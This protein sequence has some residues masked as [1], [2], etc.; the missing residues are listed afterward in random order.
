MMSNSGQVAGGISEAAVQ[1]AD[2]A[3]RQ[4]YYGYWRDTAGGCE[5]VAGEIS[6]RAA[7]VAALPH[8]ASPAGDV[9]G[10]PVNVESLA[11]FLHDTRNYGYCWPGANY[12]A[13]VLEACPVTIPEV[14]QRCRE[15]AAGIWAALHMDEIATALTALA[16]E[17]DRATY[18]AR[19][20]QEALAT[21]TLAHQ[22]AEA[23]VARLHERLEDNYAFDGEGNRIAVEPG[24]IPDGISCRDETI[25]LL[26]DLVERK[27]ER[28]AKLV[29][30]ARARRNRQPTAEP[31]TGDRVGG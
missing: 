29:S 17:R 22:V 20:L 23:E 16:A 24:S 2:E 10:L 11:I 28:I 9:A 26:D 7:L 27:D 30:R 5:K 18:D 25:R 19:L 14:Q 1:A 15:D 3:Y 6:T 8:L 31:A 21:A 13:E 12:D 4:A